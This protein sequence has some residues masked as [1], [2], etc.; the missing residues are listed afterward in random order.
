MSDL[1]GQRPAGERSVAD[2][3][4]DPRRAGPLDGGAVGEAA[5]GNRL[6]VRVGL[7][8][9]DGRVVRARWRAT[10]CAALIAYAEV[11]CAL[12][13]EGV[14]PERLDAE[15]LRAR[16]PGVHPGQQDRAALVAAAVRA[17]AARGRA[18]EP[19]R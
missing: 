6:L 8:W 18:E 13:E 16:L 2:H 3:V 1:P 10:T 4:A 12:L 14:A 5:G 7:W 17:A 9:R 11:A 19:D 15:V